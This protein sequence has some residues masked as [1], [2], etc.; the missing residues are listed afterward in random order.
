M[1]SAWSCRMGNLVSQADYARRRGVSEAMISKYKDQ[2][3]LVMQD[4]M[5]DIEESDK[6]IA[7]T[8]D[9]ARGGDRTAEAPGEP[10][11]GSY[12]E[13]RNRELRARVI[14]LELENKVAAGALV[15]REEVDRETFSRTRAAQRELLNLSDLCADLVPD[16]LKTAV[17]DGVE[18]QVMRICE[19]LAAGAIRMTKPDMLQWLEQEAEHLRADIASEASGG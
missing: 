10:P 14:K 5:V 17:R 18:A 4:G 9:P 12:H 3:R 15:N 8:Q 7:A 19:G 16:E 11:E 13:L 6:L 2:S 1:V